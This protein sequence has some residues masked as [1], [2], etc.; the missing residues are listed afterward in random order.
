M[1]LPPN[2]RVNAR[3]P[4]PSS[5]QGASFIS[6]SKAN[7]SWTIT[8][9]FR[10]LQNAAPSTNYL[11]AV[12][13]Q[14][15]GQFAAI[16]S[17]A[18]AQG[19]AGPVGP[20]GPAGPAGAAGAAGANWVYVS[21]ANNADFAFSTTLPSYTY[22]GGVITASAN[23]ALI[24]SQCD[25]VTPANGMSCI[26]WDTS[27]AGGSNLAYGV[28]TV[29]SIGSVSTQWVLTRRSDANT[30]GTL[31]YIAV[32]TKPLGGKWSS[33]TFVCLQA[34]GSITLGTTPITMTPGVGPVGGE[35]IRALAAEAAVAAKIPSR[36]IPALGN[37]YLAV[38]TD[39]AGGVISGVKA[40]TGDAV[41]GVE[42]RADTPYVSGGDIYVDN[43]SGGVKAF[44]SAANWTGG[45][46]VTALAVSS[47]PGVA[48][49]VINR[50]LY[51]ATS[52]LALSQ[53]GVAPCDD[54]TIYCIVSKGQSLA[55][56]TLGH[57]PNVF[58]V[59]AKNIIM[60]SLASY[61]GVRMGQYPNWSAP[62]LVAPID[63]TTILGFM[64]YA[65]EIL[66]NNSGTLSVFFMQ[67]ILAAAAQTI[68]DGFY[69]I[70]RRRV[71]LLC[72]NLAMGATGISML[73][74]ASTSYFPS[75]STN[76][77]TNNMAVM[78]KLNSLAA[79]QGK[80]LVVL[81]VLWKQGESPSTGYY[82]DLTGHQAEFNTDIQAITGQQSA[83]IWVST[84]MCGN[85]SPITAY[86]DVSNAYVSAHNNGYVHLA[87]TDY[88]VLGRNIAASLYSIANGT[89]GFCFQT[90]LEASP[91][92]THMNAYG[93]GVIGEMMGRQLLSI[94]TTNQRQKVLL[95]L[96][97]TGSGTTRTVTFDVPVAPLVLDTGAGWT[98]P[99][100]YGVGYLDTSGGGAPTVTG[101]S[102]ASSTSLLITLSADPGSRSGRQFTFG[103][104][105]TANGTASGYARTCI[106]DSATL[107]ASIVDGVQQ[108]NWLIPSS[109][110]F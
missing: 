64:P 44:T 56:E 83:P 95:P 10:G 32:T 43:G 37:N 101:V 14:N 61:G 99:G 102:V 57:F 16:P 92:Y 48:R 47:G 97:V 36:P 20:S 60:P 7:G 4:F 15:T 2:I 105:T 66:T 86:L 19:P 35:T 54:N 58:P 59:A 72:V 23:G 38:T 22:S 103:Q 53:S 106:R 76:V 109:I 75:T 107:A 90:A 108:H 68:S 50:P 82:S 40:N 28:Y 27:G 12:Q 41:G 52:A 13:D 69:A 49:A 81:G 89:N 80:N 73:R 6:V 84:G 67:G 65:P 25:G 93:Y 100:N 71:P 17:S 3:V 5:V 70:S 31:G 9:N 42:P 77:Y 26:V 63:P 88:I 104:S 30:A 85:F 39:S 62:S 45:P 21:N 18:L 1:S 78:T 46:T 94:F 33:A 29:T 87:A 51:G 11:V 110:G 91:D 79:A 34:P 96:S 8:P 55:C 24:A 74:K 98:D